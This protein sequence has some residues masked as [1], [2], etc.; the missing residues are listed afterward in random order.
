MKKW[1]IFLI[2]ILAIILIVAFIIFPALDIYK[3][4][5]E[6]SKC[7]EI[8]IKYAPEAFEVNYTCCDES[9][10]KLGETSLGEDTYGEIESWNWIICTK[11]GDG[12]C[13]YLEEQDCPEDCP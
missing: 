13:D 8:G 10:K 12:S 7:A 1:L 4:F 5:K 3:W 9:I 11:C 2:I 6:E